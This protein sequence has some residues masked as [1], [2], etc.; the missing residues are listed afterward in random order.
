MHTS[1]ILACVG[2]ANLC[3][4]EPGVLSLRTFKNNEK[5]AQALRKRDWDRATK[6]DSFT[7]TL[8]NYPYL[9]GG[10]YFVNATVGTPPQEVQLDI[11]TGSS[12]VWMFGV[13]SCDITTSVCAGG[14]FDETQSSS[15]TI[16][17]QGG[18]QIQYFTAG[19]GVRGDYIADS[20]TIGKQ[21]V[22]NLTMG[23]ATQ[24]V[25]VSTGIM[26]IGFDT[27]EAIV[28]SEEA[29]GETD[30]QPY[31]NLLDEM[32][33]QGLINVR[34]YSLYLDDLEA[35]TGSIVFGGID[36]AKFQG[37]L[38]ILDIQP[39]SQSGKYSTFGV[40]LNSVGVTDSTGSTVLQTSNM[41]NVVILDSGTAFTIIPSDLLTEL[42]TY[43]G[44]V[45]DPTYSWIVRCDLGGKTGTLDYQFA[46]PTGPVVSVPF[47]EL[48][49]PLVDLQ[50]GEPVT[51]T[52]NNPV[53]R[54]GLSEQSSANEPLLFGDTFLRSAYVVYDLDN[55]QIGIA[56]TLFN[57]TDSNIVAISAGNGQSLPGNVAS[58]VTTIVQTNTQA[59]GAA[60]TFLT[61][62]PSAVHTAVGEGTGAGVLTGYKTTYTNRATN[63]VASSNTKATGTGA[64][65][66]SATKKSG[67]T[68]LNAVSAGF[69]RGV[70]V[71]GLIVTLAS[72]MGAR[73][74]I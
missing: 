37:D 71:Q 51:D 10:F 41:P 49:V 26:G 12:D 70:L 45:N 65:G 15:V 18:F 3:L 61:G 19:S 54:L 16:I 52:K 50:T 74:I 35:D 28:A 64:T 20:F 69:W 2:L 7:V 53:C 21:T 59:I 40:I 34:S 14:A 25:S 33:S 36:K 9:G 62:T 38:G 4:A 46:G 72:I 31:A 42:T 32:K 56:Q 22:K 30:V 58:V 29:S 5:H 6:R 1:L 67:A 8:E 57:S 27:N 24:A 47:E 73:L 11:D 60:E 39:D 43:F 48:A 55:L 68:S 23:L 44:A 63:L 17:N 66:A 13:H